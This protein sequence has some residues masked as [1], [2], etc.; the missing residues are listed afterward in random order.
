MEQ[1]KG[2]CQFSVTFVYKLSWLLLCVCAAHD[3]G[4]ACLSDAAHFTREQTGTYNSTQV[5]LKKGLLSHW[6][7]E[8]LTALQRVVRPHACNHI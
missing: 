7:V 4:W 2:R 1:Q 5:F 6:L 3:R 8:S